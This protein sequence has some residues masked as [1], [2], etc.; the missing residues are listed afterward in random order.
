[1]GRL[2]SKIHHLYHKFAGMEAEPEHIA[3]GA[4]VGVFWS[5][6]PLWGFHMIL[7]VLTATILGVSRF[8]SLVTVQLANPITAPFLYYATWRLGDF[9][10]RPFLHAGPAPVT[11]AKVAWTVSAFLNMAG[12]ALVRM[13]IGGTIIGACAS[14]ASYFLILWGLQLARRSRV[15]GALKRAA[16]E[17]PPA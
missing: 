1:M 11:H 16:G 6:S 14:V 2:R 10:L 15:Q 7:C 12:S 17:R 13:L 3:G 5:L 9:L 8:A 4:A